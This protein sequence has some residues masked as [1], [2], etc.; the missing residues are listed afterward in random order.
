[1]ISDSQHYDLLG[2]ACVPWQPGYVGQR[3]VCASMQR[4]AQSVSAPVAEEDM[5]ADL[6]CVLRE[7]L[8]PVTIAAGDPG[9]SRWTRSDM[10]VDYIALRVLARGL[11]SPHT[12]LAGGSDPE[13]LQPPGAASW[14]W[15]GRAARSASPASSP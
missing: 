7:G 1:M 15:R 13:V 14:R 11:Q 3:Q 2:R 5:A 8:L 12:V 4:Y 10:R 9:E 6:E